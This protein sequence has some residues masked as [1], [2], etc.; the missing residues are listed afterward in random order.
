[1]PGVTESDEAT[2]RCKSLSRFAC[3]RAGTSSLCFWQLIIN[4]EISQCTCD[5]HRG[6]PRRPLDGNILADGQLP[7]RFT[8][9]TMKLISFS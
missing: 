2:G 5:C 9:E 7:T 3:K 4:T 1:M 6:S 8:M